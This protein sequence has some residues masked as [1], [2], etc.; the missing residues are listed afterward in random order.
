V[1]SFVLIF[2]LVE[3]LFNAGGEWQPILLA[4][5]FGVGLGL[6][7]S[8][9]WPAVGGAMTLVCFVVVI[10]YEGGIPKHSWPSFHV[11]VAPGVLFLLYAALS[12]LQKY[13]VST[14]QRQGV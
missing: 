13:K 8:W 2:F 14:R 4:F 12:T 10:V 1:L 9:C 7:V 3:I 5:P 11:I 6:V